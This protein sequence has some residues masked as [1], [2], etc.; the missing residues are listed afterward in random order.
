LVLIGQ[1]S[2]DFVD[3][4]ALFLGLGEGQGVE[5]IF[6]VEIGDGQVGR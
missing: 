4:G 6:V 1:I 3:E 2:L 5:I